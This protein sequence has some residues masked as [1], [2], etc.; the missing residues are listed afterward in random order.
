MFGIFETY[1]PRHLEHAVQSFCSFIMIFLL[2]LFVRFDGTFALNSNV[3]IQ[4]DN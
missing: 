3:K 1:T 2:M 4:W